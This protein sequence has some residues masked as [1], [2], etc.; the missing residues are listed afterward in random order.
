[1]KKLLILALAC[2][3]ASSA[4]ALEPKTTV[5][6]AHAEGGFDH[7]NIAVTVIVNPAERGRMWLTANS[8]YQ[9]LFSERDELLDL[10]RTAAGKIEIAVANRTTISY[11]R[12]V[13]FFSTDDAALVIVSFM[14]DGYEASYTVVQFTA[15]G[16]NDILLLNKKDTQDF[17][18]ILGKSHAFVDDYQR[19]A[20]LFR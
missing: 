18:D 15:Y 11:R 1:M 12:P 14:T 17:I 4:F 3:A 5:A 10:I 16:N 19:Q 7:K 9:L 6:I 2:A 8:S 20:A 13:G